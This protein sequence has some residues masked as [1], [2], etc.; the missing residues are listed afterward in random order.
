MDDGITT[1]ENSSIDEESNHSEESHVWSS[2]KSK[3]KTKKK[4][5]DEII[6]R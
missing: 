2:L 6:W 3:N 4:S 1:C 5:R